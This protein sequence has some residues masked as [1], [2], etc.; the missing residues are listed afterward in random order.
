MISIQDLGLTILGNNPKSFY[1]VG[2]EEYGIKEKYIDHLAQFYGNKEEYPSVAELIDFLSLKHLVPV[3]PTLYVIRYDESFVS[4]VNPALAKKIKSLKFKGTVFCIYSEA[5]HI[6]KID[7]YLP[8][9]CATVGQINATFVAKYLKNDFPS[10][11]PRLISIAAKC[12]TDYGHARTICRS[13]VHTDSKL[14]ESMPEAAVKRLFGCSDS[15]AELDI[16]RAIAGRNFV[17]GINALNSYE[18]D[19]DSL[20]YTFLQTMIEMEKVLTSRYSNSDLKD[21]ARLWKLED[22]YNMFM[23]AYEELRKLRSNTSSN[24]Y[25]SLVYLFALLTFK[26]IPAVEVINAF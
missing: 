17:A 3:P 19:M 14:L 26:D 2:G 8:E 23:N 20:V 4:G 22:V 12:S 9:F 15:S 1:F 5:K 13:M 18:G 6:S 21:Y 16:Q 24:I 11:S 7:K 25:S 10:L